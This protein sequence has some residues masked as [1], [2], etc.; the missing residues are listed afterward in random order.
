M[1]S[2]QPATY[3]VHESDE[4]SGRQDPSPGDRELGHSQTKNGE[5]SYRAPSG[6]P[7]LCR[8][9]F[10][11][12][13]RIT[14]CIRWVILLYLCGFI[15]YKMVRNEG[16]NAGMR[17]KSALITFVSF[18]VII[19]I[20]A[21]GLTACSSDTTTSWQLICI[22]FLS[23]NVLIIYPTLIVPIWLTHYL[24]NIPASL[25]FLFMFHYFSFWV[26]KITFLFPLMMSMIV[27]NQ[28]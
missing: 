14:Y 8:K 13:P 25:F 23:L 28:Y 4:P 9:P 10:S 6:G 19:G 18:L 20:I 21:M 22:L 26:L 5:H 24:I 16:G 27:I 7:A 12:S 2:P 11:I 1:P 3:H 17:R 15:W